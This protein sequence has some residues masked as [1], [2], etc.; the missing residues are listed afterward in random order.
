MGPRTGRPYAR[1]R[2]VRRL[3]LK[4][5]TQVYRQFAE[6][7]SFRHSVRDLLGQLTRQQGWV[8]R[9]ARLA[10]GGQQDDRQ[11]SAGSRRAPQSGSPALPA[12]PAT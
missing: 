4:D 2:G 11:T 9:A 8:G 3:L 10:K 7:E 5:D 12:S 6:N 1:E